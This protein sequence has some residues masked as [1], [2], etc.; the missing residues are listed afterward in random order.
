MANAV[1]AAG[2]FSGQTITSH[3]NIVTVRYKQPTNDIAHNGG[4][5]NGG[6][7]GVAVPVVP[8]PMIYNSPY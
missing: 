5:N 7:G 8:V 6:Y 4:F 1:Y 2:S 3:Q